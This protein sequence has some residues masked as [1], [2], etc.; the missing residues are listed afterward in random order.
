M[1]GINGTHARA[2]ADLAEGHILAAVEI[3][4]PPGIACVLACFDVALCQSPA[5]LSKRAP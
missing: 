2:V 5:S 1:T 4:A 3:A